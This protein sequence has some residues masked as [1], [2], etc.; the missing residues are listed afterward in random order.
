MTWSQRAQTPCSLTSMKVGKLLRWNSLDFSP[1][2]PGKYIPWPGLLSVSS[3]PRLSR[4]DLIFDR[5]VFEAT[6][7]LMSVAWEQNYCVRAEVEERKWWLN[8]VAKAMWMFSLC[9]RNTNEGFATIFWSGKKKKWTNKQNKLVSFIIFLLCTWIFD[10]HWSCCLVD[11]SCQTLCSS[12]DCSLPGSSVHGI[13][14]GK[15]TRVGCHFLLQGNL[16]NPGIEPISPVCLLH[17]RRI[18]YHYPPGKP[19]LVHRTHLYNRL[20]KFLKRNVHHMSVEPLQQLCG[21]VVFY[22]LL[23]CCWSFY[24]CILSPH[25][26]DSNSYVGKDHILPVFLSPTNTYTVDLPVLDAQ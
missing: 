21:V 20:L 23:Q 15:N 4:S 11:Q 6:E 13:S 14:P 9:W 7:V 18:L 26:W 17:C 10:A 16:P 1:Q 5:S 2:G 19:Y 8:N 3:F 24:G 25:Q 22:S 12:M